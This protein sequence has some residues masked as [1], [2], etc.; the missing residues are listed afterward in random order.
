MRARSLCALRTL[1]VAVFFSAAGTAE[2]QMK[3]PKIGLALSGGGAKGC[4]HVG[5]LRQL[6]KMHIP[7]DYI[8]GTSMGA[9][10]GALYASGMT[11]DEIEQAL[12]TIDWEE[13]LSDATAFNKLTYRRKWEETRYPSTVEVGLKDGKIA[14]G[15]GIRTGQKLSFLLSRLS[16]TSTSCR[17]RTPL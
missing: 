15:A 9:V 3:R 12:A 1:P 5:V 13:V 14:R 7:V 17:F 10:I 6:E 16:A 11:P 2:A 4:A 8:A